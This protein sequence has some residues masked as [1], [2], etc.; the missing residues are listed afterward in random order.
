MYAKGLTLWL[1]ILE[2]IENE[3]GFI[4]PDEAYIA[5]FTALARELL[6]NDTVL[7]TTDPPPVIALG[8]AKDA[9]L[10]RSAFLTYAVVYFPAHD[11][12]TRCHV[13]L[14]S[15][16]SDLILCRYLRLL[17]FC[18]AFN[19]SWPFTLIRELFV[20]RIPLSEASCS[21]EG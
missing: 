4:G 21:V 19:P 16:I 18:Y 6:G 8:G 12:A 17:C 14:G 11:V 15:T 20:L 10:Y 9:G 7:Y 5:H 1:P 3:F 13:H 2:Q